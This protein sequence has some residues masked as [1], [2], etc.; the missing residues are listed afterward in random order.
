LHVYSLDGNIL[1]ATV[2]MITAESVKTM[3]SG[4]VHGAYPYERVSKYIQ[5]RQWFVFSR[6]PSASP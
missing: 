2:S 1:P 5:N 6:I 3:N 4:R